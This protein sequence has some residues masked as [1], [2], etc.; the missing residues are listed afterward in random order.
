MKP[1]PHPKPHPIG[2]PLPERVLLANG[3]MFVRMKTLTDLVT[4]WDAHKDQFEFACEGAGWEAPCFLNEDE[5]VFGSSKAS[6][7]QTVLRWG[8]SDIRVGFYDWSKS[9]R[10]WW[11]SW[12]AD[13][14]ARRNSGIKE[15][16]WT[17][18]DEQTYQAD[19][20]RRSPETYRGW[21]QF[22]NLPERYTPSDW[23]SLCADELFDPNLPIPEVERLLAEQTFDDW[24][25][26][27]SGEVRYY[28]RPTLSELIDSRLEDCCI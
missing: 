11:K 10:R 12:F 8:K 9:N 13:R 14:E 3:T 17:E 19:C 20:V 24:K 2:I 26:E 25:E 4:F 5:W 16:S 28:D 21:W 23:L 22:E 6:V 18:S 7:V 27:G 1:K 15:G